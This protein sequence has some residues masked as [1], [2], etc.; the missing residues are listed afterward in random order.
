KVKYVV[1]VATPPPLP[2]CHPGCFP[3]GTAIRVPGGTKTVERIREGDLVMTVGPDGNSAQARVASV[4][5]T[6]NRL[7]EVRTAA[8]DLVTTATQP[9]ALAGGGLQ[10]AGEL[11]AGD[12][13]FRW[14]GGR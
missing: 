6:K 1:D 10:A 2:P 14:D 8:G 7:L 4:F 13:I 11:K 3:A 9:L 5:V 12:R